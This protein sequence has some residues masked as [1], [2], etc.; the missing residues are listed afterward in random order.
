[1][2]GW[3]QLDLG[4]KRGFRVEDS[5]FTKGV[6]SSCSGFGNAINGS[7]RCPFWLKILH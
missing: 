6:E 4:V 5:Y 1:M 3:L 2:A 7:I